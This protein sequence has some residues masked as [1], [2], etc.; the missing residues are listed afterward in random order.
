MIRLSGPPAR[1]PHSPSHTHSCWT[2]PMINDPLVHPGTE[3]ISGIKMS[4]LVS[5]EAVPA[6]SWARPRLKAQHVMMWKWTTIHTAY[7]EIRRQ[8]EPPATHTH[9]PLSK[10]ILFPISLCLCISSHSAPSPLTLVLKFMIKRV[11][12]EEND[13]KIPFFC[14]NKRFLSFLPLGNSELFIIPV[15]YSLNETVS[16]FHLPR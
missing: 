13:K 8:R 6:L 9:H 16:L 10:S 3:P 5:L 11:K 4:F 7:T 15:S 14:I 1:V 12:N 2:I